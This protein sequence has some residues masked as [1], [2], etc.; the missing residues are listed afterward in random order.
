M[1]IK[2]HAENFL[3]LLACFLGLL[4]VWLPRFP[5]MVDLPQHAAQISL[6]LNFLSRI[7]STLIYLRLICLAT[8]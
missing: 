6:F 3:F 7:Y 8:P 5:S 4:P 1:Q 2:I